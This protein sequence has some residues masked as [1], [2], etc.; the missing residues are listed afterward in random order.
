[1]IKNFTTPSD[2]FWNKKKLTILIP[3]LNEKENLETLIPY[4][5]ESIADLKLNL[6]FTIYNFNY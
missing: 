2:Q 1:M 6:Q 5:F 3:A 4:I